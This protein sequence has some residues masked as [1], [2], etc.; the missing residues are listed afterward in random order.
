VGGRVGGREGGREGGEGGRKPK[1]ERVIQRN[2][3]IA[4]SIG[5]Q[6]FVPYSEVSL[7]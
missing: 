1:K 3:S 6:H 7:T 5:N 2:P 4:D